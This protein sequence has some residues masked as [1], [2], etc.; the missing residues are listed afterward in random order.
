MDERDFARYCW[1]DTK[2][3]GNNVLG[4]LLMLKRLELND[5]L[6][7]FEKQLNH[8]LGTHPKSGIFY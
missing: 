7:D 1:Q 3:Y 6:S 4:Y 5:I 2:H 8:F